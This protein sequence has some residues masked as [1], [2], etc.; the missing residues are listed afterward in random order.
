MLNLRNSN[1]QIEIITSILF[2]VIILCVL[3]LGVAPILM[4]GSSISAAITR[5][6]NN[7]Y[8]VLSSA[9]YNTIINKID[10][11]A[12]T[13]L[14]AVNAAQ[15]AVTAAETAA[16]KVDLFNSAEVFL[17]PSVTNITVTFTAGNTN[18][19]SSWAE[20]VDSNALTLSSKFAAKSGYINDIYIY[21]HS[22]VDKVYCIELSYGATNTTLGRLMW[23]T[24]YK[25]AIQIKTRRVPAGETIY[26]RM[27][28]SGANGSTD[29]VGFRYFFE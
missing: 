16:D 18:T 11:A 1:G 19:W 14:A 17:F 28:C 24:S 3:V 9:E 8:V 25:D 26:Y 10:L 6:E 2:T 29:K 15:A 4:S 22:A 20:I 23:H 13:A 12:T 5:L 7:E 21:D 27:M